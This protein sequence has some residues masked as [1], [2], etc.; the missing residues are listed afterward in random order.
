MGGPQAVRSVEEGVDSIIW[1]ATLEQGSSGG[2]YR[3]RKM[4]AW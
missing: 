1:L 4:I 2:F 3:D